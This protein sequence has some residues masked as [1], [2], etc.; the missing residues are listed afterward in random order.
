[1]ALSYNDLSS[2][3]DIISSNIVSPTLYDEV[4]VYGSKIIPLSLTATNVPL[5]K[6]T[7]WPT[8]TID[9]V[10]VASSLIK[11]ATVSPEEIVVFPY[12]NVSSVINT[13]PSSKLETSL[14]VPDVT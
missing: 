7:P 9:E 1:M 4:F 2:L 11:V 3:A 14:S 5:I 8:E 13:S 6:N 10:A 12:V